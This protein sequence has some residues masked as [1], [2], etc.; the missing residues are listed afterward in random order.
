MIWYVFHASEVRVKNLENDN[1]RTDPRKKKVERSTRKNEHRKT[2]VRDPGAI[3]IRAKGKTYTQV[4]K[5]V[6]ALKVDRR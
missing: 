5:Q 4:V 3:F 6:R 1:T 2:N